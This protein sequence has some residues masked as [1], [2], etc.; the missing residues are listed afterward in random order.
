MSAVAIVLFTLGMVLFYLGYGFPALARE[1]L[2][3]EPGPARVVGR[4]Q[5]LGPLYAGEWAVPRGSLT[6]IKK[7]ASAV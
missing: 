7:L 5:G 3:C 4:P 6:V 1:C 2:L